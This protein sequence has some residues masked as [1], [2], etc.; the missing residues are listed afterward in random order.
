ME[1][2]FKMATL[3]KP[4]VQHLILPVCS[5]TALKVVIFFPTSVKELQMKTLVGNC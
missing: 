5:T 1:T 3:K 2:N 4:E